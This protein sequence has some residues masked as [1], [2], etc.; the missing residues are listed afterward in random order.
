MAAHAEAQEP[1]LENKRR[2]PAQHGAAAGE[3]GAV[4][5]RLVL[6]AQHEQ[7]D[8]RSEPV[9]EGQWRHTC[10]R[11]QSSIVTNRPNCIARCPKPGPEVVMPGYGKRYKSLKSAHQKWSAAGKPV[12]TD[13]RVA[14]IYD[15]HCSQCPMLKETVA[16]QACSLCGC[17]LS[18]ER[19]FMNKLRW[20]TEACPDKPP[21]WMS[22][23][24]VE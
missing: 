10:Q 18:R 9:K 22:E 23:I 19:N 7:C 15:Q 13:E 16:G 20:A 11:C 4:R 21:R 1:G 2:E 14:E 8:F 12:R 3:P 6:P 5:L 17:L 24:P